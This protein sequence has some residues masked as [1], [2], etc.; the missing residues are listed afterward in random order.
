MYK[1]SHRLFALGASSAIAFLLGINLVASIF[2]VVLAFFI[3][4]FPDI[5]I[6]LGLHHRG[7]THSII[8]F[9]FMTVVCSFA[10]F[11]IYYFLQVLITVPIF[12]ITS[13]EVSGV[14]VPMFFKLVVDGAVMEALVDIFF[15]FLV[16]FFVSFMTHF[17]LDI[18]TP[19]G[20]EV[21]ETSIAGSIRSNN[22]FF[23]FFF[24]SIGFITFLVSMAFMTIKML[25][26][27]EINW[28][29]W[30]FG[31]TGILV[32]IVI[33]AS[34]LVRRSRGMEVVQ[35]FHLGN[36]IDV[37]I[38]EGKC[39]HICPEKDDKICNMPDADL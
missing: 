39:L 5:D 36:N 6:K 31:I 26:L 19:A 10:V 11:Y 38:P 27:F 7:F 29:F 3:G 20:L 23:N 1:L 8:F 28:I 9:I 32:M 34:L 2:I 30:Y 24:A 25:G 22:V 21:G 13:F 16:F 12:E 37:C 14:P 35:C 15:K 33:L 18:I 4:S 17:I